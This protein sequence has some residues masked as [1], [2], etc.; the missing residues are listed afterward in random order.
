[1]SL[2]TEV[3]NVGQSGSYVELKSG[4]HVWWDKTF[5]CSQVRSLLIALPIPVAERDNTS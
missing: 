1:M 4:N 5:I 3:E 2:V